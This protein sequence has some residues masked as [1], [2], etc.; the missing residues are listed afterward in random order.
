M[1]QHKVLHNTEV[2]QWKKIEIEISFYY[3]NQKIWKVWHSVP[4]GKYLAAPSFSFCNKSI[5]IWL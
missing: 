3:K 4:I 2:K 1:N 5:G